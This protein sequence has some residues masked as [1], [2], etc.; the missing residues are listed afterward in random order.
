MAMVVCMP[1]FIPLEIGTPNNGGSVVTAAGLI[2]LSSRR[3]TI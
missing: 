1:N 2:S 3:P